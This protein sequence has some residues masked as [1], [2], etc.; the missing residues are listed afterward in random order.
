VRSIYER[1]VYESENQSSY[2]RNGS[3]VP[4]SRQGAVALHAQ[5]WYMAGWLANVS[6]ADAVHL[7]LDQLFIRQPGV[8]K[9]VSRFVL[10]ARVPR[11]YPSISRRDGCSAAVVHAGT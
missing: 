3:A 6:A 1:L 8:M 2:G 11:Y 7:M 9:L 10:Y 4:G 5:V